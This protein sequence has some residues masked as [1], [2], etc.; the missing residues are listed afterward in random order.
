[1][2]KKSIEDTEERLFNLND[3][4]ISPKHDPNLVDLILNKRADKIKLHIDTKLNRLFSNGQR[5]SLVK[6]IDTIPATS[7]LLF[8]L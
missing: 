6:N 4:I 7:M 5:I 1:M 3:L 8:T 2:I